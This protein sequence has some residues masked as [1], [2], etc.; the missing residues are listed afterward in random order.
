MVLQAVS[1]LLNKKIS[2]IILPLNQ[3]G[4]EQAEKIAHIGGT[5]CFLNADT[6]SDSLL[7]DITAAKYTHILMSPEFAVSE[8]LR[9]IILEPR[10]KDRLALVV[11]DEA[12]LVQLWGVKF[13]TDY[14]RLHLLRS[15]LGRHIPLYLCSATLD[16]STLNALIKGIG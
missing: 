12:H 16:N 14:T 5:P 4:K 8:R 10:F 9:K 6:V 13:R 2:I 3:I 1:V 15:L 11:I 7:K